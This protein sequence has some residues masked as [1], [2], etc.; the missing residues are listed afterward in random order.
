MDQ[1]SNID[2]MFLE[3]RGKGNLIAPH[4]KCFTT[5]QIIIRESSIFTNRT[6]IIR[7]NFVDELKI[8]NKLGNGRVGQNLNVK[9]H[10]TTVNNE[11]DI[12]PALQN[13]QSP[14]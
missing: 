10:S 7:V 3:Q 8:C 11:G 9:T 1:S 13:I 14:Y 2:E 12:L 5:V 4:K 6:G